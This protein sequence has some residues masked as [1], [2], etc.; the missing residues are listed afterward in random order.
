ME[1]KDETLKYLVCHY[2]TN[3]TVKTAAD[4]LIPISL[5]PSA[6]AISTKQ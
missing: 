2:T 5:T 3:S 6:W 1:T 4:Q